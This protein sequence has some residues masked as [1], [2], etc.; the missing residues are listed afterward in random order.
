MAVDEDCDLTALPISFVYPNGTKEGVVREYGIAVQK[1]FRYLDMLNKGIRELKVNGKLDE[2]KRR[3]WN[4][5]CNGA[6]SNKV[7]F[8][9]TSM[10]TLFS[11][12]ISLFL[13]S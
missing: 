4:R 8:V 13:L 10:C 9:I 2:L 5:K 3:Y 11:L 1:T 12:A 7:Q 6:P